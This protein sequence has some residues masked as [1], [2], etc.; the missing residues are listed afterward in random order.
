VKPGHDVSN[1]AL[2]IRDAVHEQDHHVDRREPQVVGD[3]NVILL[4]LALKAARRV[5]QADLVA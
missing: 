3:P 2:E 4:Q 5:E 1:P